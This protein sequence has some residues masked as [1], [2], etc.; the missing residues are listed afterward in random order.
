MVA[1]LGRIFRGIMC[2]EE[3]GKPHDVFQIITCSPSLGFAFP[4]DTPYLVYSHCLLLSELFSAWNNF[5][6]MLYFS[7]S[8]PVLF[9]F[10]FCLYKWAN[11]HSLFLSL[12]IY[13]IHMNMC[14]FIY[15]TYMIWICIYASISHMINVIIDMLYM[16]H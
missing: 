1:K 12:H 10:L 2:L 7:K 5:F 14:I 13:E 9:L 6:S 11:C 15:I 3:T 8:V 4:P 16:M